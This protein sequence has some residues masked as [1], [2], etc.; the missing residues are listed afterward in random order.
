MW[1]SWFEHVPPQHSWELYPVKGTV[2]LS[3]GEAL[4]EVLAGSGLCVRMRELETMAQRSRKG[5]NYVF[6]CGKWGK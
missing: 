4:T 3:L 2:P 5:R 1:L 6:P